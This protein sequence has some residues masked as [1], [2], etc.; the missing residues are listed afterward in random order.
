MSLFK[1]ISKSF[2]VCFCYPFRKQE[3]LSLQQVK[4]QKNMKCMMSIPDINTL[5]S[6][7]EPFFYFLQKDSL[8]LAYERQLLSFFILPTFFFF[9]LFKKTC[10][11]KIKGTKEAAYISRFC[12]PLCKWVLLF[13]HMCRRHGLQGIETMML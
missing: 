5:F 10:I 4:V 2:L 12:V 9:L 3:Y 1:D 13:L 11:H 7:F 8:S 6:I